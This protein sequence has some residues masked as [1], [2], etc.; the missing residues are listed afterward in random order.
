M[1]RSRK[2][3]DMQ[4]G[5]LT[6]LEKARKKMEEQSVITGNN[7]LK[8][9]PAEFLVSTMAK[10]E[11][12]RITEELKGTA[13]VGNLDR[14]NLI[15]YC[16]AWSFYMDATLALADQDLLDGEKRNAYIGVQKLYAEEVRKWAATCGLTVDARLKA[17]VVKTEKQQDKITEEFGI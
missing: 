15:G 6:S 16:N 2:P 17:A 12:K 13:I 11:W 7:Q 3:A 14:N 1:G 5:N 10:K 9:I 4:K 8:R